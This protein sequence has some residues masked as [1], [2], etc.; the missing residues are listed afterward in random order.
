MAVACAGEQTF[1][2]GL[3]FLSIKWKPGPRAIH[4]S[5]STMP[6][7]SRGVAKH[8]CITRVKPLIS[9][10]S[11]APQLV[12]TKPGAQCVKLT[13]GCSWDS[14]S[15]ARYGAW[16]PALKTLSTFPPPSIAD[17]PRAG[18]RSCASS[19]RE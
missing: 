13:L 2:V 11:S 3:P 8:A 10:G 6:A 9:A 12:L 17:R 5:D 7:L 1:G 18:A 15:I 16:T 14:L 4:P 19:T